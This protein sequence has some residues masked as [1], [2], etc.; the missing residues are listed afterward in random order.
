MTDILVKAHTRKRPKKPAD[1]FQPIISQKLEE[2]RAKAGADRQV[3]E[4]RD[5]I[6]YVSWPRRLL[7]S[8][9]R[10]WGAV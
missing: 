5:Q 3:N 4:Y 9:I 1:P 6:D 10:G 2:W 8:I 7:S